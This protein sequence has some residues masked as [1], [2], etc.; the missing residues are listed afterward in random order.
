MAKRKPK[1]PPL[2]AKRKD[3]AEAR[4]EPVTFKG[5]RLAHNI[6]IRMRYEREI[7]K[8]INQMA[9]E[10]EREIKALFKSDGAKDFFAQDDSIASQARILLNQLNKRFSL[11]FNERSKEITDRLLKDVDK[12]SAK[13]LQSSI[14]KLSGGLSIKTDFVSGEVAEVLKAS[15]SRNVNLI[16]SIQSQY[17]ERIEDLVMRSILPGGRGLQ[18]LTQ[19]D[20]IKDM[21]VNRGVNIAKDQTRKA[22]NN[23]NAARMQKVGLNEFI[24]RHS[25]GGKNPRSLHQNKL[26]GNVYSLSDLPI[27]DERTGERGIPGQLPNCGCTMEPVATFGEQDDS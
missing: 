22:Y 14:E 17:H 7:T 4:K 1:P 5:E 11:I 12:N 10:S 26:A 25:G 16:K 18:D 8:L 21:T 9:R 2:A 20:K 13:S 24:W 23:I 27:I 3:W 19:L 6:S 15:V